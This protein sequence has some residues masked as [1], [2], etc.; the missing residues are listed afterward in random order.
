MTENVGKK[1]IMYVFFCYHGGNDPKES[2]VIF[3][4]CHILKFVQG[5]VEDRFGLL[6]FLKC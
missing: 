4:F 2:F 3:V 1:I 5:G 6:K